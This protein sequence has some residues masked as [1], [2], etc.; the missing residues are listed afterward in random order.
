MAEV[1]NIEEPQLI[2]TIRTDKPNTVE[3]LGRKVL[4]EWNKTYPG[5]EI[6]FQIHREPIVEPNFP[7][8]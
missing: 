2:I 1:D 7:D 3:T 4:K 5:A 6:D 8:N